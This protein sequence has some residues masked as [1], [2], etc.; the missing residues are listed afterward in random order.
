MRMRVPL[1]AS[2]LGAS[3]GATLLAMLLITGG[4]PQVPVLPSAPSSL[5]LDAV[6]AVLQ[7]VQPLLKLLATMA[8][9]RDAVAALDA[10][11]LPDVGACPGLTV[12]TA[13][14]DS[15]GA[16]AGLSS[17][18]AD[19]VLRY[20][21]TGCP[22]PALAGQTVSGT[23]AVRFNRSTR[24]AVVTFDGVTAGTRRYSGT[25]TL[26]ADVIMD[27]RLPLAGSFAL[28]ARHTAAAD[29]AADDSTAAGGAADDA[30]AAALEGIVRFVVDDGTRLTVRNSFVAFN[31]LLV[32]V[33]L[34]DAAQADATAPVLEV[35]PAGNADFIPASGQVAFRGPDGRRLVL[36]FDADTPTRRRGELRADAVGPFVYR[37][38]QLEP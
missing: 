8:P 34:G 3:L 10:G 35:S 5:E 17:A 6:D 1:G 2:L 23:I 15:S 16:D 36:A 11:T 33:E 30:T 9:L 19:I 27:G 7:R 4:C 13:E 26:V 32:N 29:G 31:D 25:A 20:D 12:T 14:G 38:E 21:A 28:T 18:D 24:V 22:A 37:L